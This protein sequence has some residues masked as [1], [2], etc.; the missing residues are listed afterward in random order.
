VLFMNRWN[1]FTSMFNWS[2]F[3]FS[4]SI[5]S[6]FYFDVYLFSILLGC[7]SVQYFISMFNFNDKILGHKSAKLNEIP[8]RLGGKTSITFEHSEKT[9]FILH[10]LH[11]LYLFSRLEL[12]SNLITNGHDT[13]LTIFI[14]AYMT[15]LRYFSQICLSFDVGLKSLDQELCANFQIIP[16]LSFSRF[17]VIIVQKWPKKIKF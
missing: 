2:V 8:S 9:L 4:T 16:L 1:I 5:C 10:W 3:Y 7:L 13:I 6:V 11:I 17:L 14:H 12:L 15:R